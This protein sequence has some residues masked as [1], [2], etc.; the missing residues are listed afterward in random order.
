MQFSFVL[1]EIGADKDKAD[2]VGLGPLVLQGIQSQSE[3]K[4]GNTKST[5]SDIQRRSIPRLLLPSTSRL[6]DVTSI[7]QTQQAVHKD[8]AFVSIK[9]SHGD[10]LGHRLEYVSRNRCGAD[11]SSVSQ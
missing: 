5:N 7:I 10:T 2:N 8:A 1:I 11:S 9:G 3:F 4:E 6:S